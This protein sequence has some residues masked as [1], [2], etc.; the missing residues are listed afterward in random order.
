MSKQPSCLEASLKKRFTLKNQDSRYTASVADTRAILEGLSDS[1]PK[2]WSPSL[3]RTTSQPK[4]VAYSLNMQP[5]P[6]M[7]RSPTLK[8]RNRLPWKPAPTR[9]PPAASTI[10]HQQAPPPPSPPFAP[11]NHVKFARY[12]P[13]LRCHDIDQ[14]LHLLQTT[15]ASPV[16]GMLHE[17]CSRRRRPLGRLRLLPRQVKCTRWPRH[18]FNRS[19]GSQCI[20]SPK[21]YP[22]ISRSPNLKRSGLLTHPTLPNS[23]A[24][25]LSKRLPPYSATHHPR[26][27]PPAAL[28]RLRHNSISTRWLYP[29]NV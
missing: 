21:P 3:T 22:A 1:R 19:H 17:F 28:N 6:V 14:Q 11:Q 26:H 4:N 13:C 15:L 27:W 16:L 20:C 23:P 9:P 5:Q 8:Q 2:K 12:N 7:R 24:S 29:H 25:L 18:C 10:S